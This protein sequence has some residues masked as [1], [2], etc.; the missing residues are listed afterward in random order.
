MNNTD[1]GPLTAAER[2]RA[3]ATLRAWRTPRA[4]EVRR[5]KT[6]RWC[7]T[8]AKNRAARARRRAKNATGEGERTGCVAG[9]YDLECRNGFPRRH[10]T[11]GAK[12]GHRT[13][14][15]ALKKIVLRF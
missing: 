14:P 4:V 1:M 7:A 6:I 15:V 5:R 10:A 11:G 12:E 9:M 3:N 13:K 2:R 8:V